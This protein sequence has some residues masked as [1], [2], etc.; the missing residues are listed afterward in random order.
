MDKIDK[1]MLMSDLDDYIREK[2]LVALN[3]FDSLG[4]RF[5]ILVDTDPYALRYQELDKKYTE[6][7]KEICKLIEY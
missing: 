5:G 6:V 4:T 7:F 2:E 1:L 3:R